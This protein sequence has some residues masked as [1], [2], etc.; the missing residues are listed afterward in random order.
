L[1]YLVLPA[2]LV[3]A[4][5]NAKWL[6]DRGS[7]SLLQYVV[8]DLMM[9]GEYDRHIGRMRRRYVLRR[10]ALIRALRHQLGAG[11]EIAGGATGLHIVAWLPHLRP[12]DLDVLVARCAERGIGVYSVARH[13]VCPLRRSG[14]ILGYGLTNEDAIERGVRGLA[15][16][17]RRLRL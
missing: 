3:D 15:D 11:V 13:A 14:L 10:D 1:G 5:V 16:V 7:S 9:S 6:T 2:M 17:Y 8:A 12:E 4:A